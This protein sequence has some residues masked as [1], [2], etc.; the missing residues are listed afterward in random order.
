MKNL[1]IK[2]VADFKEK[3]YRKNGDFVHFKILLA[4]GLASSSKRVSY[5][6]DDDQFLIIHE[7]DQSYEEIFTHDLE[8]KSNLI[9]AITKSTLFLT[10]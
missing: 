3:A 9:E 4:G 5:R 8:Q 7:I 10:D 1:L 2:S 6:P